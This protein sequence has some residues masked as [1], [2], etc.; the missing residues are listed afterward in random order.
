MKLEDAR[1]WLE[2]PCPSSLP[3][4][5]AFRPESKE[6]YGDLAIVKIDADQ[7]AFHALNLDRQTGLHIRSLPPSSGSV[8]KGH[9]SDLNQLDFE[10]QKLTRTA[11]VF[12]ALYG[13]AMTSPGLYRARYYNE[14]LPIKDHDGMSRSP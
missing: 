9:P 1:V 6:L 13:E 7:D 10:K 14:S 8:T 2:R 4:K 12:D 5:K 3:S 11:F